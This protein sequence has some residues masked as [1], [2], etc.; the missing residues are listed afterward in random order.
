[1]QLRGPRALS[2][3]RLGKLLASLQKLDPGVRSASAE[4]RYFVEAAGE[5]GAHEQRLLE[6]LLDDG[7]PRPQPV[8]GA[9]YLVVPRLGTISP[10]SSKAS[11]IARNCGLEQVR[12]IERA[13]AFHIEGSKADPSALLHDRMTQTV[14]RSFDEAAKLFEHVPPRPL[15][16][17]ADLRKA[18]RELGL[19]LSEDEIEYLERAY[20]SLGRDPT[21]VEL[22]MFAQANSEHCRHKIFNADWII[23]GARQ[24]KSLFGM[25]RHTHA[26]NP[27]GTVVAYSD[28]AAIMEG[29]ETARFYPDASGVYRYATEPTHILMKVETHNHPTAISPFPGASTGAGGEIASGG[30]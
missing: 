20:R 24:E 19:A 15:Q 2:E 6:R 30:E 7:S 23:D 8:S 16:K 22:T 3:S 25:V 4:S 9:L 11:D 17:I 29:A 10:W 26:Q 28:N 1:M 5:L 21:D 18:N 12:R 14:L 27:Q 13:T